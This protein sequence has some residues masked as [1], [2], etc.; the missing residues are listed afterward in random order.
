VNLGDSCDGQW[1]EAPVS[2]HGHFLTGIHSSR[3]VHPCLTL[4]W[5]RQAGNKGIVCEV[6][7]MV[8]GECFMSESIGV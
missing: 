6:Y 5:R 3:V 4:F 2:Q 8:S 1:T 7:V